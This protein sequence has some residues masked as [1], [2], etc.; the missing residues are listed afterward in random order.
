MRF[1][2]SGGGTAGHIYPAIAVGRELESMGHEVFFAGTPNGLESRLVPQAGFAFEAFDVSGF[3]RTKPMTLLKSGLKALRGASQ[4][5]RW[6]REMSIDGVVG[7]GGYVSIPVGKAAS[8]LHVPLVLHEQNSACGMAN[9]YLAPHASAIAI[10]YEAARSALKAT[11]PVVLTGNPVR[12]EMLS[13]NR[14]EGRRTL[15]IPL[16]DRLLLVFGGSLGARHINTAIT[17]LAPRLMEIADLHVI[18]V[19]GPKEYDTVREALSAKGI[20]LSGPGFSTDTGWEEPGCRYMLTGYFEHMDSALAASDM[21]VSRSGATT[22][23]EITAVGVAALLVPYPHATDDHQTKNASALVE[24]GAALMCPDSEV[25]GSG[26]ADQL[27]GLLGDNEGLGRMRELA[28]SMGRIDA[29]SRVASLA[30]AA[31]EGRV[32]NGELDD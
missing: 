17:A 5:K 22:L 30:V 11:C 10:T 7:F 29:A 18:H 14:E 32:G 26:F 24:A 19:T 12:P 13:A 9:K 4:A 6:L 8:D 31:A 23:A 20:A 27:F 3:N 25:E 15:G 21:V 16:N 28:K 2:I 1:A